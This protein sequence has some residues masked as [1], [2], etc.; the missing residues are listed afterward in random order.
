M[1]T[2]VDWMRCA[3][4]GA[5]MWG[6]QAGGGGTVFSSL[7]WVEVIIT[8]KRVFVQVRKYVWNMLVWEGVEL[9]TQTPATRISRCV[10]WSNS[11]GVLAGRGP[12]QENRK[13]EPEELAESIVG[14]RKHE[15][16]GSQGL[17]CLC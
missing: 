12:R 9:Y 15:D 2:A 3:G 17:V 10:L 13:Q 16:L 8:V 5:W 11:P 4:L 1:V 7:S 6:S 14:K